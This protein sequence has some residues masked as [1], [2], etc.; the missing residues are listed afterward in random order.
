MYL[1]IYQLIRKRP[2]ITAIVVL[3]KR[4]NCVAASR[5]SCA[6]PPATALTAD[7]HRPPAFAGTRV[8]LGPV[9]RRLG[10]NIG[11]HH[12]L[13]LKPNFVFA[14]TTTR[15]Y[16]VLK[17]RSPGQGCIFYKY[18]HDLRPYYNTGSCFSNKIYK[19]VYYVVKYPPLPLS[20]SPRI[21]QLPSDLFYLLFL[22]YILFLGIFCVSQN[23]IMSPNFVCGQFK[24][25]DIV[26]KNL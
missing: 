18:I 7:V 16:N 9:L 10:H 13:P 21:Q 26:F 4:E 14:T 8:R 5:T 11:T 17:S 2:I 22:T 15:Q 19:F 3:I 6:V 24:V 12:T 1:Y 20:S 23:P 25:A